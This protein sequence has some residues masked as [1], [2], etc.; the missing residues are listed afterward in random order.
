M[1]S[2]KRK[3]PP[4]D[5][6]KPY[7]SPRLVEHGDLRRLTGAKGGDRQDGGGG[8]PATRTTGPPA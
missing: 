1:A 6:R 3:K 5:A 7:R 2:K 4:A 8:K